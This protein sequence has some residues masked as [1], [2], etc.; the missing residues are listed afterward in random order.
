MLLEKQGQETCSMQ[1]CHKPA[2]CLKKKTKKNTV[3]M[4]HNKANLKKMQ[5]A[6][7]GSG[8]DFLFLHDTVLV[9]TMLLRIYLFLSGCPIC[10]HVIVHSSLLRYEVLTSPLSFESSFFLS[11]SSY[12]FV[13]F[14][15]L[16]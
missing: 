6:S 12:R 9:G 14:V 1:G 8:S 3:S 7:S 15:Y 16:F 13:Y 10:W 2:I 4:K 11:K 5:F